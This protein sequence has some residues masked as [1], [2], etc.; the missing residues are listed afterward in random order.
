M[1]G[2]LTLVRA[3]R[4]VTP[5]REGGSLPAVME[6]D[7][8]GT[9]VVKFRGAGQ[10][11]KVLVAEVIVSEIARV[12]DIPTPELVVLGLDEALPKYERDEEVQDLLKASVGTNLGSDFLPGSFGYDGSKPPTA[13]LAAR[14]LWLDAYTLNIDRTWANPNIVVWHGQPYAI[15]HGAALWFHHSW[16]RKSPDPDT[17]ARRAFDASTHV[18]AD[19]AAPVA[20]L[21]LASRLTDDVLRRIVDLVPDEWLE[22][23]TDLSSTAQVRKAYLNHLTAR[24]DAAADWMAGLP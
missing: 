10:G 3:V 20:G 4:Y 18:L 24:R 7:D 21:D 13:D 16:E 22:T 6:A 8:E 17:F 2:G 12:L 15:D 9:Y 14:I 19:V 1:P 11:V 23:T 5:L